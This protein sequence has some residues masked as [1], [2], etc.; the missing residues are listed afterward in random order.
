MQIP[1]TSRK[2]WKCMEW[3]EWTRA[4]VDFEIEQFVCGL[5]VQFSTCSR[6]C[7]VLLNWTNCSISK[8]TTAL[9]HSYHSMH[10]QVFLEVFG[11]YIPLKV[12][13][14]WPVSHLYQTRLMWYSNVS[15]INIY[16]LHC[17]N[18][19]KLNSIQVNLVCRQWISVRLTE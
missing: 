3:Y 1:N 19:I 2:T 11:F 18:S 10:F 15:F 7:I 17:Q 9:V 16:D 4:V 6:S 14:I 12:H 13:W 5:H 8:S